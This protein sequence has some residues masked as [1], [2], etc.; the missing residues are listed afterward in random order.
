MAIITS[1]APSSHKW[2]WGR[3]CLKTPSYSLNLGDE[4]G[5]PLDGANKYTLHFDKA[6]VPPMNAFWS[7]TF[8]DTEGYP[9]PNIL[10]RFAVSSWMPFCRRIA[11][12]QL[13]SLSERCIQSDHAPLR[14][15]V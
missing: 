4:T 12:R 1:S 15:E 6:S 10:N 7:V 13:A 11:R 3:I 9:V 8:Y 2:A 5:K 14:S